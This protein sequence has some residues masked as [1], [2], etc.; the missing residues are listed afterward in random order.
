[1][2]LPELNWHA[3][4]IAM[5]YLSKLSA[6][7]TSKYIENANNEAIVRQLNHRGRSVQPSELYFREILV[8]YLKLDLGEKQ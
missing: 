1:M 3:C 8:D 6:Y 7:W 4:E 5:N 2:Y